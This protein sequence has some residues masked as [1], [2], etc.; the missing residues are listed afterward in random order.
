M[1]DKR[2]I[3]EKKSKSKRK[4]AVKKQ[5]I[6]EAVDCEK[7][8]EIEELTEFTWFIEESTGEKV[9]NYV[10]GIDLSCGISWASVEKVFFPFR[11]KPRLDQLF[12][13]YFLG[14]LHFQ[15]KTIYVYDSL[16]DLPYDS[17]LEH[18]Q[19]YVRLIPHLLECLK[20]GTQNK[21]Y[22]ENATKI[23][24]IKWMNTPL[25]QNN[26]DCG[27]FALTFLQMRLTQHDVFKFKQSD[28]LTFRRELAAN[29]WAHGK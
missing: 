25:Q 15:T 11:L 29:L 20:F 19:N 24:T 12:T 1:E 28:V 4:R 3:E 26:V 8:M 13:L 23:F 21:S 5:V 14:I 7:E 2:K 18:V 6:E 22:G 17:V 9:A 27:I 10:R 16:S